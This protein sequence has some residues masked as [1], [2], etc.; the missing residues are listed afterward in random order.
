MRRLLFTLMLATLLAVALSRAWTP[1]P[2]EARLV[3]VQLAAV[4]PQQADA[5]RA[6]AVDVQGAMLRFA[7]EDEVLAAKAWLALL[8]YPDMAREVF[9]TYG[10]DA[11]FR[12]V[13][14]EHGEHAIPPIHYYMQND[15]L[16]LSLRK[17]TGDAVDTLRQRWSGEASDPRPAGPPDAV[18]RGRYAIGFIDDEG[19]DFLGQFVIHRDGRVERVQTERV[20]EGVADFFTGGIRGLETRARRGEE[21]RVSDAGW[22][23]VDVAIGAAALKFL[24]LGRGAAGAR[25][26]AASEPA[27]AAIGSTLLRGSRIGAQ[28]ARIGGPVALVYVVVR[29]P[30]LLNSAF[31]HAAEAL[32]LPAWVVQTAGWTLVLALLILLLQWLLRPLAW[33]LASC[34][35]ALRWCDGCLRGRR[36]RTAVL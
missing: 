35:A 8:R 18:Q 28:V 13:L 36:A 1:E 2:L 34:V 11:Q 17:R 29:H 30:S 23:A 5:L 27:T 15:S 16:T 22:A 32:G 10:D 26:A 14:R 24:R 19:H 33:G 3:G 21:I 7:L 25:T 20:V 4:M 6:E 12:R 9:G 31:A